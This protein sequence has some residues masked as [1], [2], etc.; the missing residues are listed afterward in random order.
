MG[1]LLPFIWKLHVSEIHELQARLPLPPGEKAA[2]VIQAR[3]IEEDFGV[4]QRSY[5]RAR[6]EKIVDF[7]GNLVAG[8]VRI[9]PID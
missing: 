5:P 9:E 7:Q 4:V 6:L 3:R 1:E 8:L 2:L